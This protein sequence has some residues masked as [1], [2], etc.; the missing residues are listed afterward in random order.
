MRALITGG[1]G[2]VGRHLIEHLLEFTDWELVLLDSS[3][4]RHECDRNRVT[5]IRH[6]LRGRISTG[7]DDMIGEVQVIF[8]LASESDVAAFIANPGPLVRANVDITLNLLEWARTRATITHFVQVST[9]E[10]Y[11][12]AVAG[13]SQRE[14]APVVP[15]TPYSASKAA[16]EALV[17]AWWRTYEVPVVLVNTMHLFGERQP[18][19]KFVPTAINK[20]LASE[21]VPVYAGSVSGSWVSSS[22]CWLYVKDLADALHWL[23][24]QETAKWPLNT[25]PGRWHVAGPEVTCYR[26]VCKVAELLDMGPQVEFLGQETRPGYEL[27]YALNTEKITESGWKPRYGF[28]AG[29]ART[30][31]WWVGH[32]T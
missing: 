15:P 11:G 26:L 12:P 28:E 30:V 31:N 14:W 3:L 18:A 17:T 7:L 5:A 29:L 2:F 32:E 20:L 23:A 10:V 27:R 22:R 9:N 19:N 8:N 6:D 24:S 16:Q 13:V 25:R 1:C 4:D 21:R